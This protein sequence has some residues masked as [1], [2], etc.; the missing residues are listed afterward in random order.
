MEVLQIGNQYNQIAIK[1][2][3]AIDQLKFEEAKTFSKEELSSKL[4]VNVTSVS[5]IVINSKTTG[6]RV[7]RVVIAG[8]EFT[9]VKIRTILGL[10]SADFTVSES[11]NSIIFKTKGW[12]HGVGMS[13]YGANGM[14]NAGYN[15]SQ[16]LKHYYSVITIT[17]K[18]D[19][20][21]IIS[22][23]IFKLF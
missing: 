17:K 22:F 15:Y 6:D 4:G 7:N 3:K 13:Q 8:K 18:W 10:R 11:E 19:E 9:G 20:F 5:D 12:G 21:Y 23:L 2:Q 14:A 1:S 16:I